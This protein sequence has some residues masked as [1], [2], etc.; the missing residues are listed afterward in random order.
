VPDKES[1]IP[2]LQSVTGL[3]ANSAHKAMPGEWPTQNGNYYS[4]ALPS[5]CLPSVYLMSSHVTKSPPLYAYHK[6]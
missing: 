6:Q 4:W 3:E 2:F 5:V 1:Q